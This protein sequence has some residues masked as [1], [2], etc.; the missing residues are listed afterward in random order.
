MILCYKDTEV[1]E[2]DENFDDDDDDDESVPVCEPMDAVRA[3]GIGC[4]EE[5]RIRR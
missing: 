3:S 2:D 4:V 1:Y 5:E